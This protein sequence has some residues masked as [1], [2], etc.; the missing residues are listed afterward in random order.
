MSKNCNWTNNLGIDS[1]TGNTIVGIL[2]LNGTKNIGILT[3]P[4]GKTV[5]VLSN[6]TVVVGSIDLSQNG[7]IVIMQGG[8]LKPGGSLWYIDKDRD[9]Y[10]PNNNIKIAQTNPGGYISLSSIKGVSDCDDSNPNKW[11][12][13]TGYTD[14]DGD[15]YTVGSAHQ[16]CSGNSL[17]PGYTTTP[18]GNDCDDSNPNK[19]R[20][21]YKDSDGDGRCASST[22]Y[23]VGNQSGYRSSCSSYNDCN[24]SNR[25]VWQRLICYR[26]KDHDGYGAGG[27]HSLCSGNS[28]PYGYSRKNNDYNDSNSSIYPG[29]K[30]AVCKIN[31]WDGTCSPVA[32]G[33]DPY[34]DCSSK[35]Q[36][37]SNGRCVYPSHS[38]P[39]PCRVEANLCPIIKCWKKTCPNWGSCSNYD[40]NPDGKINVVDI[41][42]CASNCV[43]DGAKDACCHSD[44]DCKAG[45]HC[46]NSSC[47]AKHC[48]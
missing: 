47:G 23:C 9:G 24:D 40:Y 39:H 33:T 8:Q 21:L 17:P 32:N 13:L 19:W 4:E 5:T 12:M 28:C 36:I 37:C 41:Q 18:K 15:G 34:N 29:R 14:K 16:I 38:V 25:S 11:R 2:K 27:A 22:K 35:C 31:S 26:D 48:H 42:K 6:Q 20:M 46:V 7:S 1:D 3:I 44:S 45:L 10:A 30:C 43:M